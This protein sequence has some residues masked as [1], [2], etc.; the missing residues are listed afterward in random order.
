MAPVMLPGVT[1]AVR[2][3]TGVAGGPPEGI[4]AHAETR[5]GAAAVRHK[6]RTSPCIR[7][8]FLRPENC[9]LGALLTVLV[10]R[11]PCKRAPGGVPKQDGGPGDDAEFVRRELC[12]HPAQP[13]PRGEVEAIHDLGAG[14][15]EAPDHDA[16]IMGVLLA[17]HQ[18]VLDEPV[19]DAGDG[20]NPC[21]EGLGEFAHRCFLQT[22]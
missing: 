3:A 12:Q 10:G 1:V 15:G 5:M 19:K 4:A 20:G 21:S 2:T 7:C 9:Y 18:T 11:V 8:G 13:I 6:I 14:R 16:A 17:Y 22:V